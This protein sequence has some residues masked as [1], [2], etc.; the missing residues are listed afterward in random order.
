[1]PLGVSANRGDGFRRDET[2]KSVHQF[3]NR[4]DAPR[5]DLWISQADESFV[6]QH[7]EDVNEIHNRLVAL[8]GQIVNVLGQRALDPVVGG[9]VLGPLTRGAFGFASPSAATRFD[10]I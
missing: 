3:Q 2:A 10:A 9:A 8:A 4:L 1:M 7:G 5:L 6:R